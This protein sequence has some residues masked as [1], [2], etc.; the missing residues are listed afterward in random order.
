MQRNWIGR[1]HGAEVVFALRRAATSSCRCSPPGPTRSSARPSSCW[2]PSTRWRCELA[3]GTEHEAAVADYVR[4]TAAPSRRSSGPRREGEDRRLHR[5]LRRS[6][7]VNGE[8]IPVWVA[9]YVLMEYG[10]GAIMAVPAHDE[11]DFEFA[12]RRTGSRS[13]RWSRPRDGGAGLDAR[14]YSGALRRRGAGE[15]GRVRRPRRRPRRTRRSSPGWRHEGRGQGTIAYRLRDWLLSRQRYWGCPIPVVHCDGC[16]IVP[17]PDDQLPVVLPD[18]ADY[19]PR[20]RS[21]LAA[22]E[23]WV[24]DDV[25]VVRRRGA[26]RD[27]HDGHVRRLVLVLHALRR[28]AQRPRRRSTARSS[29]RGCRSTSTSAASSTPSCT[30]CTRASSRR[31]CTTSATSASPSRSRTCSRRG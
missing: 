29:T 3:A 10:T 6:I 17:V 19:A 28:P 14:P 26:A 1:S 9:D 24:N 30:C 15:L 23:E 13:G 25:P 31:R 18:I 4:H 8:R 21:P 20:G 5:P 27:R 2:R 16:G 7:P 22:A 12:A 11:R